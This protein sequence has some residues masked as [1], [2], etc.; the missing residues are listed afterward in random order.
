LNATFLPANMA[1]F[2]AI[3]F[4]VA[5]IP[6]ASAV[7]SLS[8]DTT[9]G[10]VQGFTDDITPNVAQYFGIPF[11]EQPV[12]ARRWLP[13]SPKSKANETLQATDLG[14]ACPQFEGDAPNVW[15]T[16]APEFNIASRDVQGENCLN[17]HVWTPWNPCQDEKNETALLPVVVWIYGGGFVTGGPTVEYQNPAR[18]VERSGSHI[19]VG[20]K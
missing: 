17:L 10:L 13:P 2:L 8:I 16:D 11:A 1:L 9:S 19:I 3:L 20:I 7:S 5:Q 18:W 4:G 6:F 15:R 12:G 14:P